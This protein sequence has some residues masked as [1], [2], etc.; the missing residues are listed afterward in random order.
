M[1]LLDH[2]GMPCRGQER[3][4]PKGPTNGLRRQFVAQTVRR[5]WPKPGLDFLIKLRLQLYQRAVNCR[6]T[7]LWLSGYARTRAPSGSMK[8]AETTS[9]LT[10]N[11]VSGETSLR[12]SPILLP[13]SLRN[14]KPIIDPMVGEY[15]A[16]V[17]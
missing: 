12:V 15:A 13:P 8:W 7:R 2:L 11:L 9:T 3:L 14:P 5:C 4:I 17:T 6:P 10:V 16:E 1:Q